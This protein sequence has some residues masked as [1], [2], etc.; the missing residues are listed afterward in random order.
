MVAE[1]SASESM[2][3]GTA[4][5]SLV[6]WGLSSD[7]DL[8][9]RT[10]A[11]F[12]PRSARALAGELGLPSRRIDDA[13]EELHAAGAA[14][15][16]THG[17]G[18][19]RQRPLWATRR[20][21][22]V[23]SSLRSRRLR[24]VDPDVQARSHREVVGPLLERNGRGP[25]TVAGPPPL[26]GDIGDGVRYLASR[27]WTRQRLAEL[28]AVERREHLAINT[29]QSFD[30]ASARAAGPLDRHL[31]QRGVRLRV[32][33]L[34][35]ADGDRLHVGAALLDRPSCGY[36]EAPWMPM[37]LII[38]DQERAFFPADPDDLDRGYLEL[39][40]PAVVRAL[41]KLFEQHWAN[42]TDPRRY[43]MPEIVLSDSERRLIALLA[44]GHTDLTA[45]QEMHISSRSVTNMMRRL[46]DRLGVDNRF[47]L[48]LA[49][50]ALR[51]ADLPPVSTPEES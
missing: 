29:E 11:T 30:A 27:E 36:R 5:P 35:P 22:D 10:V 17:T 18:R 33:G 38:I 6:R 19:A 3:L 16:I 40:Q 44:Q 45:A 41:V 51:V 46:M 12:G 25:N 50:G 28:V 2:P 39:S 42:A 49:L 48:G 43:R 14:T 23:V 15:P 21:R 24:L 4:V 34:P 31:I 8:V 47:Q 1:S 32:L 26:G 13:L 7:A 20:P 37:K 9:F